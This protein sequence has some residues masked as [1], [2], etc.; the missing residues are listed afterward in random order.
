VNM[1]SSGGVGTY[2]I[3]LREDTVTEFFTG[4]IAILFAKV[5]GHRMNAHMRSTVY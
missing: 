2:T 5:M 3:L 1:V 4:H